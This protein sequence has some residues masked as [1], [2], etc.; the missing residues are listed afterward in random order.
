MRRMTFFA[1][2]VAAP[3]AATG[4]DTLDVTVTGVEG[5]LHLLRVR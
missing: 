2:V 1:L 4:L 5:V 3:A